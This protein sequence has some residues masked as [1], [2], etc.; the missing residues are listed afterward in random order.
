MGAHREPLNC[1]HRLCKAILMVVTH[2]ST[3]GDSQSAAETS[4]SRHAGELLVILFAAAIYLTCIISPPSLMDDVDSVQAQAARTMLESGDWVTVRL[5]GVLILEKSPMHYW[6]MAISY[7]IFGVH[8]WAA[9]IPVALSA[10]AL[11]WLVVC[12]GSWA[13]SPRAGF[14]SGLVLATCVG[15]WLFTRIQ[16]PDVM[17]TLTI[18]LGMCSFLRL[19][20]E[21]EPHPRRWAAILGASLGCGLLLKALIAVVLPVGAAVV[22]LLVTQQF[23]M[24]RTWKRLHLVTATLV[25]LAVAAPWHVLATLRNPPYFEWT[26]RSEPGNYHGFFWSYFINE[27]VL[28]FLNMRYPRDYNTVPRPLFW[29]YQL[30]WL[31]P[32]SVYLPATTGLNYKPNDR[33]GRARLLALCW[34]G[35]VIAFFTLSTTQEYYSMPIYPALALLIGSAMTGESRWLRAGTRTAAAI[36]SVCA[37][38]LGVIFYLVRGVPTPGDISEGLSRHPKLY[39]L[40]LGH[41]A[42]LT[43]NSFAYLRTPLLVAG[44]AFLIG[45]VGLW[46]LKGWHSYLVMALMMVIFFHAA[47]LALVAFDPYLSSRAIANT[48]LATP[49]GT[50][51]VDQHYYFFSSVFFYTDRQAL[52]LNGRQWN[53]EYGSNAPDAPHVFIE[54]QDLKRLW[55]G[56]E[57]FYLVAKETQLPRIQALLGSSLHVVKRE[58]DKYMFTNDPMAAIPR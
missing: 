24:V 53:F 30:L 49:P 7:R 31:F 21:D 2:K 47:R 9:R 52:L 32:W 39:S 34:I 48:L 54:D 28:R 25:M 20:E 22:Y 23:F 27:Q 5:D 38:V 4:R 46:M 10:V 36:A 12:F 51:I 33:A 17:L 18:T 11:C 13:I 3:Q 43:L 40:S 50:L 14:Y 42:D 57:R 55:S 6:M 15:L 8:D 44:L 1:S 29:A 37:I 35:F 45:A 26:F 56:Q 19:L 58:G 16:I 41:M